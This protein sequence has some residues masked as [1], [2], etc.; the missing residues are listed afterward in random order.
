V[1]HG[2]AV[3]TGSLPVLCGNLILDHTLLVPVVNGAEALLLLLL[4]PLMRQRW[5][6]QTHIPWSLGDVLRNMRV[7]IPVGESEIMVYDSKSILNIK[8]ERVWVDDRTKN[9]IK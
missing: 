2:A 9:I 3:L 1:C 7:D 5:A 4:G 6:T 8:R